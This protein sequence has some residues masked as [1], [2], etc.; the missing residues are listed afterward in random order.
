MKRPIQAG[1][2]AGFS[3]I[4]LLIAMTLT[5]V[6]SGAIF[7]LLTMGQGAFRREPELTERQQNLR[8]AM[9]MITRDLTSAGVGLPPLAQV[10]R[11]GLAGIGPLGAGGAATDEIQMLAN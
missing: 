8:A 2:A 5:L 11:P 6:I 4:E 10:F 3:L 7:G 1:R 9:A